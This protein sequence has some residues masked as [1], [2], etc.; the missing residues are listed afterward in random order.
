MQ[1]DTVPSVSD[2]LSACVQYPTSPAPLR[3]AIRRCLP[4]V[5]DTVRVLEVISQWLGQWAGRE[6]P[7]LPGQSAVKKNEKGVL[8]VDVQKGKASRD[9]PSV[10]EVCLPFS[11]T[12]CFLMRVQITT[13]LQAVMDSS[14]L[15]LLQHPPAHKVLRLIS[16]R[17]DVEIGFVDQVQPLRGALEPFVEAQ[18]RAIRMA[19]EGKEQV[20]DAKRRTK[21]MHEKN[22]GSIGAYRVEKLVL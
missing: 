14:L 18:R 11:L 10:D 2:F 16:S 3:M 6:V 19:E 12:C 13:F 7:L 9:L 4:D 22:E 15:N 5:A 20:V 8:V 17:V 21:A 1:I